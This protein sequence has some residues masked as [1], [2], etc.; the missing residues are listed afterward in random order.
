MLSQRDF[1]ESVTKFE[2]MAIC[3]KCT[4]S[5]ELGEVDSRE[6]KDAGFVLVDSAWTGLCQACDSKEVDAV[7]AEHAALQ[8]AAT[9]LGRL[10]KVGPL[11]MI[12]IPVGE[13]FELAGQ[14]VLGFWAVP[15]FVNGSSGPFCRAIRSIVGSLNRNR[16][17]AL[18]DNINDTGTQALVHGVVG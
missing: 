3:R 17:T 18:I 14:R 13:G 16:G 6:M 15:D 11:T 5:W 2:I 7:N 10:H 1:F 8:R 12:T 9:E 4:T